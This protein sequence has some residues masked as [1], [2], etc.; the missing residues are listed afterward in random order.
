MKEE[1][2]AAFCIEEKKKGSFSYTRKGKIK[3]KK[4]EKNS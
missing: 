1:I 2:I 4:D 3:K